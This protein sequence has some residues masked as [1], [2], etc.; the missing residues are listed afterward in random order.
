M[1]WLKFLSV[2]DVFT[3]RADTSDP[4]DS[5][6][7]GPQPPPLPL[8]QLKKVEKRKPPLQPP[9]N[10]APNLKFISVHDALTDRQKKSDPT[11]SDK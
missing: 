11:E 6:A 1:K 5:A 8:R 9:V 4:T 2:H 3:S 10:L 7:K